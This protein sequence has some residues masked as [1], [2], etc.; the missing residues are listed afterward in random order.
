VIRVAKVV[1]LRA[2]QVDRYV[3]LHKTPWPGVL[4]ALTRNHVRNYSIYQHAGLLFSYFEYIGD[5]YEADMIAIRAD[6][7]SQRWV[8]MFA[9]TFKP[10]EGAAPGELRTVMDEIFHLD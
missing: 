5:D 4:D 9:D 8:A 7:Q 3:E 1:G 10:V 6:P 2:G